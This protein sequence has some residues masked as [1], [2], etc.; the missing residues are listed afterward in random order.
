M[1]RSRP[2]TRSLLATLH[3][4]AARYAN[5]IGEGKL[6]ALCAALRLVFLTP[7]FQVI[8]SLRL[9]AL[10]GRLPL[11]GKLLRRLLWYVT[12]VLFGCD[13]DPRA[14]FGEGLYL[15]HPTG[16]VIGGEWDI[17]RDVSILQGVT[18]GRKIPPRDRC[19]VGDRTHLGAGAKIIGELTIGADVRVGANAVVLTSVPDGGIAVGVPARIIARAPDTK[20]H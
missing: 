4:D 20:R 7:G 13:I 12:T 3:R 5:G 8:L 1:S 9:Q 10:L 14:T 19:R 16:V 18:L 17:G 11:V 6:A 2:P 15:P